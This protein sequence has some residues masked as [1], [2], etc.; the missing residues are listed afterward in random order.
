MG[1]GFFVPNTVEM[2]ANSHM[3]ILAE[4][5]G[6]RDVVPAKFDLSVDLLQNPI[7]TNDLSLYK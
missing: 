4:L 2:P 1:G 6:N 3:L 7:G 5:R